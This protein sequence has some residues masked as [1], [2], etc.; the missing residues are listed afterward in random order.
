MQLFGCARAYASK[1]SSS[2][3]N[4]I[5]Q[6]CAWVP[7]TGSPSSCPASTLEV[8]AQPPTQAARRGAQPAV[9][10]LRPAQAEL[11]DRVA[12]CR[13]PQPRRLRGDQRL[14]VDEVE[15]RGLD[16]LGVQDRPAHA[17][18]RLVRE[19]DRPLGHRVDVAGEAQL[20]E[21]PQEGVLEER[22][23]RRCPR[24]RRGSRGPRSGSGSTRGNR[25]LARA[26]R[27]RRSRP[28][29]GSCG[30]TGGRPPRRP[31]CR[32]R[33]RPAPWSAGR[34]RSRARAT[35]GT[36]RR[37]VSWAHDAIDWA[38]PPV[39]ALLSD[40]GLQDHYVGAMKGA[41]L[42]VA[43]GAGLVDLCPRDAAA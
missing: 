22:P 16:E 11:D 6:L 9:E 33:R 31:P 24:A 2:L 21:Q 37:G 1:A 40:F 20:A 4:A 43:P 7:F 35:A 8:P 3:S 26:R 41:I 39:I 25:G 5:T 17:D 32:T 42:A 18:E 14:E 38:V 19:H 28:R 27:P 29:T 23:C 30:S 10:A 13:E 12:A 36:R 15:Q 34:D